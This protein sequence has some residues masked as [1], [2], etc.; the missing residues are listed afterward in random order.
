MSSGHATS[1]HLHSQA[2]EKL[3]EESRHRGFLITMINDIIGCG[4]LLDL[5]SLSPSSWNLVELNHQI[6]KPLLGS[7]RVGAAPILMLPQSPAKG[8]YHLGKLRV[9]VSC[10][11]LKKLQIL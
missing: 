9:S 11:L 1:R 2:I 7:P 8:S 10:F 5:Q 3:S 6:F 4:G